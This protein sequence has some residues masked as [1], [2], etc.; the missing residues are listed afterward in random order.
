MNK[1]LLPVGSTPLEIAAAQACARMADI[2][3]PL[4]KLWNADTCPL[5]LLPYLAW[6]WSVDR[7][8]ESWP[9]ATKRSVVKAAYTVHKRKGTIGAIRRVVEP[10]GYLIKVIEWWKTNE[11]PGTFR[12]DVGVLET[13]ITEEMYQELERLIDDAKPCSRHLI[14]LSINLDVNGTIPISA[15]SY[16]GDEMTIYPYLPETITVSGQSYCGG[17][18]HLIDDMRVNP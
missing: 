3:V 5:A 7:W 9:E 2:E 18:V 8:D 17:V 11:T 4:S 6:A 14:G 12:L 1:R 16:D 13:G 15:A 10:L